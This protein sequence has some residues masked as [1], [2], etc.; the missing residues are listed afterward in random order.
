LC[1]TLYSFQPRWRSFA[2]SDRHALH[3]TYEM[4][5]F[6]KKFAMLALAIAMAA[7]PTTGSATSE[8]GKRRA[9]SICTALLAMGTVAMTGVATYTGQLHE[10]GYGARL[11]GSNR[12]AIVA[13]LAKALGLRAD[14]GS[15]YRFESQ[16]EAV[17]F[18]PDHFKDMTAERLDA[19]TIIT[20][21]ADGRASG[22]IVFES[23]RIYFSMVR[24]PSGR[25]RF[26]P[27]I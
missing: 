23:R 15:E 16:I 9:A 17:G 8:F 11:I 4:S 1:Q 22:Y 14:D 6:I 18:D 3:N 13:F 20:E 21:E 7:M 10:R 5:S 26:T 19:A 24:T 2:L 27:T 25:F 12:R